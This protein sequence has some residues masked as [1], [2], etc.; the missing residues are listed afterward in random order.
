MQ[1]CV[2]KCLIVA[3]FAHA[4]LIG[5]P[6]SAQTLEELDALSDISANEESG[7]N[8]ARDQAG[9]GEYL[10]ALATLERVLAQFP[11]SAEAR[12]IHAIYLCEI[13]DR[14]GGLVE[15]ENLER[16]RYTAELLDEA[17]GVC[18]HGWER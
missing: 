18:E 4:G 14:Q 8:A 6:A 17:R 3:L 16:R 7:I 11:R 15:I 10:E 12:L 1:S 2:R 9:R 5:A 13:D